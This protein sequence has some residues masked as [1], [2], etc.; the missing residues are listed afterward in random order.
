MVGCPSLTLRLAQEF[1]S[2]QHTK[3]TY[4]NRK[5]PGLK[6]PTYYYEPTNSTLISTSCLQ[7]LKCP[8]YLVGAFGAIEMRPWLG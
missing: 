6:K 5:E 2:Y 3:S 4:T 7:N 8:T 1:L